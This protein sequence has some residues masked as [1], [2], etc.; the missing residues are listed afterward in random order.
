MHKFWSEDEEYLYD[1]SSDNNKNKSSPN[2]KIS[3]HSSVQ[4]WNTYWNKELKIMMAEGIPQ[5]VKTW[6]ESIG[7]LDDT[8]LCKPKIKKFLELTARRD[9]DP[10]LLTRKVISESERCYRYTVQLQNGFMCGLC[11]KVQRSKVS[12]FTQVIAVDSEEC[13][14]FSRACVP[15]FNLLNKI[16]RLIILAFDGSRC[17]ATGKYKIAKKDTKAP[18][19]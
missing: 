4:M 17:D 16:S 6:K 3:P 14:T 8:N 10:T 15:R 5:L 7:S 1:P 9:Y 2:K 11:N 19:G 13:H 12:K 18:K